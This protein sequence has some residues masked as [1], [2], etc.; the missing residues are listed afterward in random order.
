[1]KRTACLTFTLLLLF[2]TAGIAQERSI[3][4]QERVVR[5][6]YRKLE[7]Y[8]AAAQNFQNEHSRRPFRD[9]ANLHFTLSDLRFG[10]VGEILGKRY[11]E[12]VTLPA[13]EV[14][15]LTRGGHSMDGG[16]QEAT[17]AAAWEAGSYAAVFD[18][19]W[20]IAD[21][22]H[23]EP[24]KYYDIKSYVSYQVTV[25]LEGR[26]RTYRALALFHENSDA[27]EFWDAIVNGMGRVWEEK[28]P[29]YKQT[30]EA[31]K[32][33]DGFTASLT[34]DTS[35]DT[36]TLTFTPLGTWFSPD[37]TEHA[38]G[39]HVGTANF[40]GSCALLPGSLQRCAVTVSNFAAFDSGTLDN[41]TPFFSHIGS[42][43]LKTENRTGPTGTTVSCAAAAGVAF[44]SCFIGTSCGTNATVSLSVLIASA[45]AT[46]N[47]GNLWRDVNAEHFACSI[48]TG[49]SCSLAFLSRCLRFGD[50]FDPLT[51]TCSGCATCG[52]SPV[53]IDIAGNGITLTDPAAGVDFDLKGSGTRDRLSWTQ[54][55]S[56]DAWLALDR[57][58]NG[59]ID[60]GA[61]LFGDFTPQ[62][63][64]T[65]KNGFLALAEFDKTENGGNADGVI[66]VKDS[67]FNSL[68]LWQDR[69]HNGFSEADELHTLRALN[70]EA[71]E[72]SFKES[73]R[74]DDFG[75][76]FKYRARV[77]DAKYASVG[78]WAWDVFLVARN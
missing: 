74:V 21:V 5:E 43:D 53:V 51:C 12:L 29:A 45:S 44:N 24:A 26:S 66:D 73:N 50:D 71:L 14:V 37:A 40:T 2:V 68:R 41:F 60:S 76:E 23:F 64:A 49:S 39:E 54:P 55:D 11:T 22:F 33:D 32:L 16:P 75:N 7:I 57:N 61:E 36:S 67:I 28:R 9:D 42:K 27:P 15:S 56:D 62:P 1:M 65:N 38:S 30:K 52:G 17:F 6:T 59:L 3:T 20:T 70:V 8:N 63:V 10:G 47:G 31:L 25:K 69:N 58:S 18:P 48:G 34:G 77:K 4:T 72:L 78:R 46:V 19:A 35:L 13:G